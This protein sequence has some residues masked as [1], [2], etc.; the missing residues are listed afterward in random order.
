MS[1]YSPW[2]SAES[3]VRHYP[4][5]TLL[6]NS[7][8]LIFRTMQKHCFSERPFRTDDVDDNE[9]LIE[10]AEN[11]AMEFGD[12]LDREGSAEDCMHGMRCAYA[13]LQSAEISGGLRL[14]HGFDA[15]EVEDDYYP[16]LLEAVNVYGAHSAVAQLLVQESKE[17]IQHDVQNWDLAA[18][19]MY[20][21]LYM[22]NAGEVAKQRD[23]REGDENLLLVATLA[24]YAR[25]LHAEGDDWAQSEE[26]ALAALEYHFPDMDET[27]LP[28]DIQGEEP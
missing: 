7:E 17:Y 24:R 19:G 18:I 28:P 2:D 15:L 10:I 21:V 27:F 4:V 12:V 16:P 26:A 9:M 11:V 14:Y 8:D 25:Q 13:L 5:D 1:E 6:A 23:D 22:A 20:T 3:T